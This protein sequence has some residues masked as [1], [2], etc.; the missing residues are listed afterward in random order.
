LGDVLPLGGARE[1]PFLGER[2]EVS[3]L[4]DIHKLNLWIQDNTRLGLLKPD[5][6]Q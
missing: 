5:S 1:M 2:D 6:Q 4:A 3:K